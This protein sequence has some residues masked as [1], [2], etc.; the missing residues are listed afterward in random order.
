MIRRPPIS[1]LFP[2]T[3]LFRSRTSHARFASIRRR[4]ARGR[5]G[6]VGTMD[7]WLPIVI[8]LVAGAI[9]G[10]LAGGRG[11]GRGLGGTGNTIAGAAGGLGLAQLLQ[12]LGLGA[13][14]G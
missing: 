10:N 8:Q 4:P 12:L 13:G 11:Q 5:V 9:G 14:G 6:E 2:Y 7:T 1:T 3:T